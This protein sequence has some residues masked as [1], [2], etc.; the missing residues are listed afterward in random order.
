MNVPVKLG[1]Y[2]LALLVV[3]G[4]SFAIGGAFEVSQPATGNHEEHP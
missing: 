1:V 2:V 4:A 3:F